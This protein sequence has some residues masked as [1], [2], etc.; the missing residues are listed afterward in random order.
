MVLDHLLSC[1]IGKQAVDSVTVEI[2]TFK[3]LAASEQ[4]A[5][6]EAGPLHGG[7]G[8]AC[9]CRVRAVEEETREEMGVGGEM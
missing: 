4:R 7:V 3:A 9:R 2:G 1:K 6:L 8:T 5:A